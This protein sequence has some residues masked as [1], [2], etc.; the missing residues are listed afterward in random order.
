MATSVDPITIYIYIYLHM[1]IH[2]YVYTYSCP[3]PRQFAL[4]PTPRNTIPAACGKNGVLMPRIVIFKGSWRPGAKGSTDISAG[5]MVC[6]KPYYDIYIY[7]RMYICIYTDRGAKDARS[8]F[9]LTLARVDFGFLSLCI[10]ESE[11][12]KSNSLQDPRMRNNLN[13]CLSTH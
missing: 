4:R 7:I 3:I 13:K 2:N 12:V 8:C 5:F 1:I 10:P 11:H 6:V 9:G